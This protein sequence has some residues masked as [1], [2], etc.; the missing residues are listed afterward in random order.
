MISYMNPAS[1]P[2]CISVLVDRWRA[3]SV[4]PRL[5][6]SEAPVYNS[7]ISSFR[8][9]FCLK[10]SYKNCVLTCR[11]SQA[12]SSASQENVFNLFNHNMA[13]FLFYIVCIGRYIQVI[14]GLLHMLCQVIF[15]YFYLS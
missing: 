13:Y 8:Y 11:C 6:L 2:H 9:G 10:C 5:A 1:K 7:S 3:G 14:L 12:R 4:S 15:S